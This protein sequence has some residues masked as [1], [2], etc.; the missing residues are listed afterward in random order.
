MED[1]EVRVR[2]DVVDAKDNYGRQFQVFS[3]NFYLMKAALRYFTV[4]Q[5]LSFTSSKVADNFPLNVS[6]AGSC[7]KIMEELGVIESRTS[8]RKRF[9]PGSSDLDRMEEVE[10]VLRNNFEI[11][12]FNP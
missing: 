1:P 9:L 10:Q 3:E 6:T 7:L 11:R 5:G 12:E 8:S 4:N 2:Q